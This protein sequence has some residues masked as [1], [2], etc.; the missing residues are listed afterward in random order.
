MEPRTGAGCPGSIARIPGARSE[1]APLLQPWG[2]LA[3]A[4]EGLEGSLG[5]SKADAFHAGH[6]VWWVTESPGG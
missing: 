1:A 3:T 2:S 6:V 4:R 5:P